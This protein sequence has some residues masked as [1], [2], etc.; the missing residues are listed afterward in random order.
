MRTDRIAGCVLLVTA[1]VLLAAAGCRTREKPPKP[2]DT[3]T[4]SIGMKLVCVPAGSFLMGS[5]DDEPRR[6]D[7]EFQH[8]VDISRAFWIGTTEVTQK[9]WQAV[10]ENNPSNFQGEELPVERMSWKSAVA[11]CRK[12]SEK[13]GRTYRLPTEAEWEYAC[14]A[15]SAAAYAGTGE[16][17][18]MGW[19]A[20]NS[21]GA[22]HPAGTKQP[23]GWGIYDMHGNVAEWCADFYDV[24]YPREEV[25][26]PNGPAEGTYR[27]VRGGSW[28]SFAPSARCAARTSTPASYQVKQTGFR[29]LLEILE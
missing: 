15:G 20:D 28:S 25:T 3:F 29:I 8:K 13:E 24:Q 9:Q 2:G 10:M 17:D 27:V 12:L 1:M 21:G 16:L 18:D 11:F 5:P 14:R 22:T 23:N 7:D 4:N 6:A 26:D 19:Y